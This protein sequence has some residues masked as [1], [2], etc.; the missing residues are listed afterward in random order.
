MLIRWQHPR[1]FA[2]GEAHVVTK[3]VKLEQ[4]RAHLPADTRYVDAA[5][6]AAQRTRRFRDYLSRLA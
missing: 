6:R 2:A 5:G 1:H 4:L 3:L